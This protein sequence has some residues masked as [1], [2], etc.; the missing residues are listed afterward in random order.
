MNGLDRGVSDAGEGAVAQGRPALPP[1][2]LP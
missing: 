1:E 2:Q